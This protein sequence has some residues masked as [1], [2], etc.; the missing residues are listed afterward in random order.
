MLTVQ[1]FGGS[2]LA[3]AEKIRHAASLCIGEKQKGRDVVTVVS[4]MGKTT[5]ELLALARTI[6]PAPSAREL[7]ALLSTGECV[8]AALTALMLARMGCPACSLTG[9][10][11][12]LFTDAAHGAARIETLTAMRVRDLLARGVV[13]VVTGYQGI[14]ASGD[15]TTLGRGGSDTTAVALASALC[16][17]R[18]DIYTDVPGIC[19]ADPRLVPGARL[20]REIDLRDM[21]RLSY[22]G[23]QVLYAPSLE[24]ALERGVELRLRPASGEGEGTRVALLRE[25]ARPPLAGL[26]RSGGTVTLV[27]R[28]AAAAQEAMKERLAAAGI[29]VSQW[30]LTKDCLAAELD[31]ARADEALR[32]LHQ[33]FFE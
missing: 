21:L 11:S 9:W 26:A 8:S 30:R 17:D 10:Q 19:T 28:A 22:A 2:S 29:A 5:D 16:A 27:G 6:T 14:D 25:S 15:V 24:L 33:A 13:P 3:D 23:A 31:P 12:G 1:K 20:L 18:C 7:D 4:A 32:V